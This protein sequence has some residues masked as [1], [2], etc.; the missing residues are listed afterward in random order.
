MSPRRPLRIQTALCLAIA[1]TLASVALGAGAIFEYQ[2]RRAYW[3][4]GQLRAATLAEAY[5]A[6]VAD[7]LQ[8]GR[9]QELAASVDRLRWPSDVRFVAV[10]DADRRAIARR[11]AAALV[12]R[13]LDLP[14][15]ERPVQQVRVAWV[16]DPLDPT[17][18]QLILAAV[19][20]RAPDSGPVL[21]TLLCA[22]R[23]TQ[24]SMLIARE[25]WPL[26]AGLAAIA[27]VGFALGSLYLHHSVVKP[28][29]LLGRHSRKPA[30][31]SQANE[32]AAGLPGEIGDLAKALTDL[33]VDIEQ[34]RQRSDRMQH[35]FAVRIQTE[36][37][38]MT[39]EL[40]QT[41]RNAWTDPLTRLG[42]RRLLDEKLGEI[43]QAQQ[44]SGD[45]L[46]VVMIDLDNFKPL[47]DTMGHKAGDDLLKFAGELLRQ[48]VREDDLAVRY[49]GDEFL[50]LLPGA[51]AEDARTIADRTVRLF[52]Q[53]T[54]LLK[55]EPRPSM[56]AGVASIRDHGPASP[57]TLLL[58]ADAALYTAKRAGKSQVAV[59]DQHLAQLAGH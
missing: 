6:Q 20:I 57:E 5:A 44:R 19:P 29:V 12:D 23:A 22:T 16:A 7:L 43:F 10:L 55:I 13:Y 38:R 35:D 58:M 39:R 34:W 27:V 33:H 47:N 48:C 11:G 51:S 32:L 59:Y 14:Q 54:R 9:L 18:S 49:G 25:A 1:V 24:P 28:L 52:A 45:D 36:T 8:A 41:Q 3:Q 53:Q 50:L 40:R 15:D 42:N 21:G 56:S 46:T 4:A 30:I 2:L 26:F 37:A 31:L 17:R